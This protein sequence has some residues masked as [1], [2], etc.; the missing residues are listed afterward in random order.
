MSYTA[1]NFHLFISQ[2]RISLVH[3]NWL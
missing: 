2:R 1:L 3:R